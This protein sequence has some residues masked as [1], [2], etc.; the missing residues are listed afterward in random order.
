VEDVSQ[1]D[2]ETVR[3][4]E[5]GRHGPGIIDSAAANGYRK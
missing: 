3:E 5:A 1:T 4:P 2:H